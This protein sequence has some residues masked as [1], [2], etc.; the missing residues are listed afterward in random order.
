ML[1][2]LKYVALSIANIVNGFGLNQDNL[3]LVVLML[4]KTCKK[5]RPTRLGIRI[6]TSIAAVYGYLWVWQPKNLCSARIFL[7][8][9]IEY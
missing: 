2:I 4:L 7:E 1:A 6:G 3:M 5:Q 9:N 8:M